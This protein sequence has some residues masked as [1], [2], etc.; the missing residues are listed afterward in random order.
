MLMMWTMRLVGIGDRCPAALPAKSRTWSQIADAEIGDVDPMLSGMS[1]G[2]RFDL[3]F[4]MHEVKHAAV[5]P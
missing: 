1:A 5:Q 4:T 2:E 3:D